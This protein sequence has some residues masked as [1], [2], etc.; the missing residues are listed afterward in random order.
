MPGGPRRADPVEPE[1]LGR[2]ELHV[3]HRTGREAQRD[4]PAPAPARLPLPSDL[5][6]TWRKAEAVD[7][8]I[9]RGGAG[10]HGDQ[11]QAPDQLA[12]AAHGAADLHPLHAVERRQGAPHLLDFVAGV[13][14]QAEPR[15]L[16][17]LCNSPAHVLRRLRAEARE[18]G[19]APIGGGGLELRE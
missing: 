1:P 14:E 7:R 2:G 10:V 13:M 3:D 16:A 18:R 6:D 9:A 12:A 11:V 19:E 15:G 4:G 17:Q 5:Y 8:R